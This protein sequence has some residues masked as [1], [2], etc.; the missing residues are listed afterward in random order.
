MSDL[1]FNPIPSEIKYFLPEKESDKD[2]PNLFGSLQQMRISKAEPVFDFEV[3]SVQLDRFASMLENV[4]FTVFC[5][6][7]SSF[8]TSMEYLL[9]APIIVSSFCFICVIVSSN[10]DSYLASLTWN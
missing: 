3:V 1:N 6:I 7:S 2:I 9:M 4:F 10:T 8:C 5:S